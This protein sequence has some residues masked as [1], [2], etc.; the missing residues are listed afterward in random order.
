MTEYALARQ[1]ITWGIEPAAMLGHSIGEYVAACLAGVIALDDAL[2]LVAER[3]RLM[4]ELP[5]GA[6]TAVPLTAAALDAILPSSLSL[7]A[8]N[9]PEMCVVSGPETEIAAFEAT[10]RAQ[11]VEPQR[12]HT[13]HAFHSAM[14]DPVAEPFA[15]LAGL[16]RLYV[17]EAPP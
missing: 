5:A 17:R 10:L 13:S 11:D 6:M 14:M 9:G 3:G 7:A 16:R 8:T 15:E 4:S 1:W 2:R 12:L